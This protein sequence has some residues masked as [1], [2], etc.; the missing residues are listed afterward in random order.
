MEEIYWF[1]NSFPIF[2]NWAENGVFLTVVCEDSNYHPMRMLDHECEDWSIRYDSLTDLMCHVAHSY[3]LAEEYSEVWE[4]QETEK[5]W[6]L[7][8]KYMAKQ[9][10][11]DR[12][13]NKQIH[14][15]QKDI[16]R[17]TLSQ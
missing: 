10:I 12:I 7:E 1:E 4:V 17:S 5:Q 13:N 2:E 8:A 16:Y 15:L 9:Y 14:S 6:F 3:E 11:I